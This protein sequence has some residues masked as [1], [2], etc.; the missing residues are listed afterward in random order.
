[1]RGGR[2][3]SISALFGPAFATRLDHADV[4]PGRSAARVRPDLP[5]HAR[6]GGAR[7]ADLRLRP[8]P[9]RGRNGRSAIASTS[10]CA[11]ATR[12]RR[13]GRNGE[14]LIPTPSQTV[15]P[16]FHLGA[17][18]AGM[19]RSDRRRRR[20]A[21]ASRSKAGCSTAT[22]R[23]CRDAMIEMWQAN[24]AGRYDHPDDTQ[25]E[26]R[27]I[28]ISAASAASRP[29][30]TALP[31][32]TIKPGPVPGR[33]NALQ[34]PHINVSV[35]ARGLLKQLVTRIYFRRRAE[36]TRRSGAQPHRRS[37]AR[38]RPSSPRRPRCGPADLP[39]RLILQGKGE[40]VLRVVSSCCPTDQK[41]NVVLGL[42]P[43]IHCALS[44]GHLSICTMIMGPRVKPEG[45]NEIKEAHDDRSC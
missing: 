38:A 14:K 31:L 23:R 28:R 2:R 32:R 36:R 24:A 25:D 27:S 41:K 30:R 11:A 34:A 21:S 22:A 40:T 29:D 9:Q 26:G 6:R 35:F 4:F 39:L 37:R 42:D 5:Q 3:T 1:M 8:E 12:P 18:P 45:D 20:G 44:E 43:R 17:R 33:G 13:S 16:F 10:C 19:G 7:A 15:G